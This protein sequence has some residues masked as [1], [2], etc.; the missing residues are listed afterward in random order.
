MGINKAFISN[1][2]VFSLLGSSSFLKES[3]TFNFREFR[4]GTF[5]GGNYKCRRHQ[6][7]NRQPPKKHKKAKRRAQRKARRLSRR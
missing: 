2:L 5:Q 4:N 3:L 1:L 7:S 6:G